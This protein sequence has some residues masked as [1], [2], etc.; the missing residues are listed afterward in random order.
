[1]YLLSH[2]T[3][4][5]PNQDSNEYIKLKMYIQ[6]IISNE[7]STYKHVEAQIQYNTDILVIV[8]NNGNQLRF[9]FHRIVNRLEASMISSM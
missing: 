9:L 5:P 1:M 3:S 2:H 7:E 6:V 4:S 8:R